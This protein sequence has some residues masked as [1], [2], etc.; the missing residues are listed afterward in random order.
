MCVD[1]LID[2]IKL[3]EDDTEVANKIFRALRSRLGTQPGAVS[4]TPLT[5]DF[6]GFKF[7]GADFSGLTFQG[8]VVFDGTEF[9][10]EHTSFEQTRFDGALKCHG[11]TFTGTVVNFRNAIFAGSPA[12]FV[13]CEFIRTT[14]DLRGSELRSRRL[15]FNRCEFTRSTVDARNMV[16]DTAAVRIERSLMADSTLNFSEVIGPG[17]GRGS[18]GFLFVEGCSLAGCKVFLRP[19][20]P[21]RDFVVWRDNTFEGGVLMATPRPATWVKVIGE[22]PEGLLTTRPEPQ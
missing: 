8:T 2:T 9:T 7:D 10:G 19:F 14:V 17:D 22:E 4:W 5:F 21:K 20:D 11:A 13:G 16:L 18:L 1:T 12:E 6:S 3:A 15:H